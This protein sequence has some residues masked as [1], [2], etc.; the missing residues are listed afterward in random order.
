VSSHQPGTSSEIYTSP[1]SVVGFHEEPLSEGD[2]TSSFGKVLGAAH[3][4]TVIQEHHQ[5]TQGMFLQCEQKAEEK[6]KRDKARKRDERSNDLVTYTN[7]C[8]LLE[9]RLTP[10]KTLAK[11]GEYSCTHLI[12][13]IEFPIVLGAVEKLVEQRKLLR[14]LQRQLDEAETQAAALRKKLAQRPP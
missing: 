9:I 4:P 6:R 13:R 10:K 7:I 3:G 14:D 8:E 5:A 2:L 12:K 1:L 11:R